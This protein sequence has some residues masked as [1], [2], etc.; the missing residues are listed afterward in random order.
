MKQPTPL[1]SEAAAIVPTSGTK[2]ASLSTR[3]LSV[4]ALFAALMIALQVAL[5]G[6]PNIELVTLFIILATVHMGWKAMFSVA[7]FVLV[8]G[9]IYGV[10]MWWIN[11]LY[12]WPI[13][14]I[15][16]MAL[17]RWSCTMLWT[18]VA[19]IYGLLFG[20]FCSIPYFITGGWAGGIAYIVAGL[21]FDLAH[22]L[23]NIASALILFYPLDR[24]LRRCLRRGT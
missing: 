11:Y 3:E 9:I 8:E 5:A 22:C 17:R 19:G 14:V 12:V 21:S 4:L 2:A 7:V 18:I 10:S 24:I 13:L 6:L 15:I 16:T 1:A 20:T 23:G